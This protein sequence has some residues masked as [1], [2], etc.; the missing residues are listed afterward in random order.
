MMVP[1]FALF[2][3]FLTAY[4][5]GEY[6][7]RLLW[8]AGWK[9]MRGGRLLPAVL[10]SILTYFFVGEWRHWFIVPV[11]LLIYYIF[12]RVQSQSA[13]AWIVKE[14]FRIIA[15]YGL[16]LIG[17]GIFPI[18]FSIVKIEL[19]LL[20]AGGLLTVFG[21]GDFVGKM[22]GKLALK[23]NLSWQGLE[24]GGMWIGRLERFLIFLLI[25]MNAPAG[26]GF[27][28]AAKSIL[29]FSET[30]EDQRVAEYVLIGT[31][32]SFALAMAASI[33]TK[34]GIEFLNVRIG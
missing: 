30:K 33:A 12:E 29:R 7:V 6:F 19:M 22:S 2:I 13:R 34:M 1:A 24:N 31:L 3:M 21:I 11:F 32:L 25:F 14:S 17:A 27:L 16:A 4:L 8:G 10:Y 28:V 15:L 5:A 9:E 26:I 23:N 18:E 20:A